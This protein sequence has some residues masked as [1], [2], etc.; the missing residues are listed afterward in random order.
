MSRKQ[1]WLA[2]FLIG[3]I[4]GVQLAA[5]RASLSAGDVLTPVIA[6]G[7]ALPAGYAGMGAFRRR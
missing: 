1:V 6:I 3:L 4:V 2:V 5:H 7:L